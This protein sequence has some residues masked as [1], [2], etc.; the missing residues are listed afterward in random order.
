MNPEKIEQ[1]AERD[2]LEWWIDWANGDG[3][4]LGWRSAPNVAG[5]AEDAAFWDL[6]GDDRLRTHY[7]TQGLYEFL[8]PLGL[9]RCRSSIKLTCV[10]GDP[11][12]IRVVASW[13]G[14]NPR[15]A[16]CQ[17]VADS[18]LWPDS[19]PDD[20]SQIAISAWENWH[21]SYPTSLF[22]RDEPFLQEQQSAAAEDRVS[23]LAEACR[24]G[25][26]YE[27]FP[28]II[29][30]AEVSSSGGW[31][32]VFGKDANDLRTDI[33]GEIV[34]PFSEPSDADAS[35]VAH[36]TAH[37]MADHG[38]QIPKNDAPERRKRPWDGQCQTLLNRWVKAMKKAGSW[39]DRST[40]LAEELL[41]LQNESPKTW[42][43]KW[44]ARRFDD[45]FKDNPDQWKEAVAKWDPKT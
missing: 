41:V 20:V 3:S 10:S 8:V 7:W 28:P 32:N 26:P 36:N 12:A 39:I 23:L 43:S 19:W 5:L 13:T 34:C 21:V 14:Q 44:K 9:L 29:E 31:K 27:V 37:S 25:P 18:H 40:F 24:N 1:Q 22:V 38:A 42:A 45:K 11:A 2:L 30:C 16:I 6:A 4:S 33:V 35:S 15:Q 17:S